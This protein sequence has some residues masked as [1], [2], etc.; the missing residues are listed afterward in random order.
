MVVVGGVLHVM[1]TQQSAKDFINILSFNCHGNP[2]KQVLYLFYKWQI[3]CL[4]KSPNFP[5]LG[6]EDPGEWRNLTNAT[7]AR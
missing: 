1:C 2:V 6:R 4:N 5:K 3:Q 7:S